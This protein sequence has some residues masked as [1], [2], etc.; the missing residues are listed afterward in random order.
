MKRLPIDPLDEAAWKRV[1]ERVV[2][3]PPAIDRPAPPSRAWRWVAGAGLAVAC[4]A[5]VLALLPREAAPDPV[6]TRVRTDAASTA[7]ELGEVAVEVAPHTTLVAMGS[8]DAGWEVV[9]GHGAA[10]F[11][12]PP[13]QGRPSFRV[14]A[15]DVTVEVVGTR[16]AVRHEPGAAEPVVVTVER[17]VVRVEARER[18]REVRAG[19]RWPA[20]APVEPAGEP[21]EPEAETAPEEP[22]LDADEPP[23]AGRDPEAT[24]ARARGPRGERARARRRPLPRGPAGRRHVGRQRALRARPPRQRDRRW[25]A[26]GPAPATLPA[27][28]PPPD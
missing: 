6:T 25:R 19:Q 11:V 12:V 27:A 15:D 13:R 28:P 5:L 10:E 21:S 8:D 2:L 1:E 7:M 16:F 18:A 23:P 9:L 22:V 17:G 3:E 24:F 20:A 26:G 4:A 14:I